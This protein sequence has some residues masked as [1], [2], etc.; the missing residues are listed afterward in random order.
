MWIDNSAMTAWF[1]KSGVYFSV[2]IGVGGPTIKLHTMVRYKYHKGN[3]KNGIK[4]GK[5]LY[6]EQE[7]ILNNYKQ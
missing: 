1:N 4:E 3:H 7:Q 6:N 5:G 2:D